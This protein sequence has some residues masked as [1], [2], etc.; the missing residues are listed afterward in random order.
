[1]AEAPD[2]FGRALRDWATGQTG[3]ETLERDDGFTETG[4]GHELYVAECARWLGAERRALRHVVGRV[5]D[6]GCGAGRV[7][8]ELQ[9]RGHD[10]VGIDASP[11]AVRTARGRGVREAWC[12]SVDD[13][14]A[15]IGAFDTVVLFGNNFGIFGTP[16]RLRRMLSAWARAMP[17]GARIL[18]GSTNPYCGGAPGLTRAYYFRNRR[19]GLLPGQVRLRIGYGGDVGPW[20]SWLFVSRSEMQTLLAGTGW[21]Q[22][23]VLGGRPSEPYVAVLDKR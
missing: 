3:P 12:L 19:R 23:R 11:L 13:L 2:V 14:T 5:V 17:P 15:R 6:V 18:A 10:V 20:F 8:L 16:T 4:M 9:R 1:M 22:T 21:R 7:A